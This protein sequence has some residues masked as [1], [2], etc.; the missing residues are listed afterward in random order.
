MEPDPDELVTIGVYQSDVEANLV[1]NKLEA[2]GIKAYLAGEEAA[3]MAWLYST[4][5]GGIRV[6][7][8]G[9][10]AEDAA[11][12]LEEKPWHEDQSSPTSIATL[13]VL[14]PTAEDEDFAEKK[15]QRDASS[16]ATMNTLR[17]LELDDDDEDEKVVLSER[18]KNANRL[19][20]AAIF[21]LVFWPLEI[22]ACW[23]LLKVY[24]SSEKLEGRPLK[25]AWV[26]GGIALAISMILLLTFMS[27]MPI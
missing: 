27:F 14:R 23:L 24:V 21:G 15:G 1:K 6:Q 22:Y 18:E 8:A 19:V 2:I 12:F 13:K 4:A 3:N 10:D 26:G 20:Q 9:S 17:Q 16:F 11:S 7:V 25:N 5:M